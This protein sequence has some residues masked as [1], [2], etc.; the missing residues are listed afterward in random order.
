[1]SAFA[2]DSYNF[3]CAKSKTNKKQLARECPAIYIRSKKKLQFANF[4][5]VNIYLEILSHP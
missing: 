2:L 3:Q 1:M 5:C 4:Y